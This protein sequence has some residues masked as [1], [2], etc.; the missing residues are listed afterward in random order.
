MSTTNGTVK[1]HKPGRKRSRLGAKIRRLE[2]AITD[3]ARV[4]EVLVG[5]VQPEPDPLLSA[6]QVARQIGTSTRTVYRMAAAGQLP[7]PICCGAR[8]RRWRRSEVLVAIEKMKNP[9]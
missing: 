1:V 6:K 5:H 2:A 3:L 8:Y 7:R 4:V 9:T